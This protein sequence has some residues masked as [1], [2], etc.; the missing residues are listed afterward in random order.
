[1][2]GENVDFHE[3]EKLS[4]EH[5]LIYDRQF[6]ATRAGCSSNTAIYHGIYAFCYI[7]LLIKLQ[8]Y[9]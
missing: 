8:N 3:K 2:P 4:D 1:V 5:L 6:T 7:F 9:F